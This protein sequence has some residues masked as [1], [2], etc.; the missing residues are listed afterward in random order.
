MN[1]VAVIDYGMGNLRSVVKAIEHVAPRAR[2][3]LT[4]DAEEVLR[5]DRVVFP[6]QGAIAGCMTA[7]DTCQLRTA[8]LQVVHTKPFLGICLGLQ[9]LFDFSE[10]GGGVKGLGV[11]TGRVP[12]FPP[13]RMLDVGTGRALKVPHMGWNQVQQVKAHPL[14]KDIP[15]ESR[16]YFVHSYYA[17]AGER[18]DVAGITEYGLRFTSA[19]ARANIFA[20]QFHPEKSAQAGLKLLENFMSW[21]GRAD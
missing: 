3:R 7:L 6:G 2:V 19:A 5:A 1:T 10:E 14:W 18:A 8:V 13:E 15:S 4:S 12:R 17:D 16:F 20:V 9:A 11:L 21:D